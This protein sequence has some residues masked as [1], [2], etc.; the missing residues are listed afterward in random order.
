M[1]FITGSHDIMVDGTPMFLIEEPNTGKPLPDFSADQ[2]RFCITDTVNFSSLS[3]NADSLKW[4]FAGGSPATSTQ[5]NP[6]VI[7]S[8]PGF[9]TVKQIAYGAQG[10]SA[11]NEQNYYIHARTAPTAIFYASP[12][13]G[14]VFFLNGSFDA[15]SV[16][17]NF[18]DGDTSSVK[19][20]AHTYTRNGNYLVTMTTF[21]PCGMSTY[22]DTVRILYALEVDLVAT[23]SVGCAPLTVQYQATSPLATKFKWIAPGG[24]INNDTVPNPIVVYDTAGVFSV[25]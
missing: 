15:D 25:L 21:N 1:T 13:G 8:T 19:F 11:V 7:Y 9:H 22:Q 18:G 10:D 17:W 12:L 4:E 16:F 14:N 2:N 23:P 5:L 24:R 20:P 3:L 6:T